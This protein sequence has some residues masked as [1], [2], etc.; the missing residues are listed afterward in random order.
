VR[1]LE[2]LRPA[3]V[4]VAASTMPPSDAGDLD[5]DDVVISTLRELTASHSEL[6][7]VL[8]PR[9]PDRFPAAA[10]KLEAAG[11]PFVRRSELAGADCGTRVVLLDTI[12]ELSGLFAY[13]DIVFMGGTLARRGGHNILEPAFFAKPVIIGPH[14]ENFQAIA[15]EFRA[16]GACVEIGSHG[17]L[18]AAIEGLLEDP[19]VAERIGRA[20]LECTQARRGATVL[21]LEEVRSL[22]ATRI[23]RYRPA[24]P[25]YL[26]RW[27]LARVWVLGARLKQARDRRRLRTLDV[28]VI[29]IGNITMGGTGKTPCV[30]RLAEVMRR[31]GRNP[32]ILTRGYRRSSPDKTLTLPPGAP[33]RA[34]HTGDEPLIFVRS[35]LAPV[36]IGGERFETG[37]L[38]RQKFAVDVLLL[39]DGFQHLRLVREVNIL[40]IDALNPFGGGDAF[41]VGRLRE[42]LAGLAR[43][44]IFVI[45]RSD[46][47]DTVPAIAGELRRW[48]TSAPIFHAHLEPA[49]WVENRTGKQYPSQERPFARPAAF[50]GLGNPKAFR[51]RLESLGITPAYWVEFEDHHRYRPHELRRIMAQ[52]R[53]RGADALLTTEKDTVNLCESCDDL[54]APLPLYWLKVTMA[55]D[56]EPEFFEELARRIGV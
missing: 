14:M 52:A 15:D 17:E 13:A 10:Q 8:A 37:R 49:G 2:T 24:M 33:A 6:A 27:L 40:L 34:E 30:L 16:R 12:G 44:D 3:K 19:A 25:G 45:T 4:W 32:G 47:T 54:L 53:A 21:A 56:Q 48:N 55:I 51:G 9:R 20:A 18:R 31:A 26:F 42:P 1:H 41:P 5:E 46:L 38:L 35:G 11:I 39:D 28:P 36:G 43:A 29:S 50:C 7:L 22:Y 23:P